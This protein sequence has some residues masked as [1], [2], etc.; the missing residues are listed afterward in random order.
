MPVANCPLK[1]TPLSALT[2]LALT[3][4]LRVDALQ[5]MLCTPC[6]KSCKRT[7]Q[8][9]PRQQPPSA[10]PQQLLPLSVPARR[11]RGRHWPL[12]A[13]DKRNS[14]PLSCLLPSKD[15][16]RQSGLCRHTRSKFWWISCALHHMGPLRLH[17]CPCYPGSSGY[18]PCQSCLC[19]PA[20]CRASPSTCNSYSKGVEKGSTAPS[21]LL[22]FGFSASVSAIGLGDPSALH[23][24]LTMHASNAKQ[25]QS[26]KQTAR[27]C[28]NCDSG[29]ASLPTAAFAFFKISSSS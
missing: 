5:Q 15:T 10:V 29:L 11:K 1:L 20:C 23:I 28:G 4:T 2:W 22:S 21:R 7:M 13:K 16:Q 25:A 26:E 17:A 3:A 27:T 6:T 18:V 12:Q 14:A 19:H 8:H 9:S 24:L